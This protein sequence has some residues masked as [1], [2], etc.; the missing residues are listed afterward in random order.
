MATESA[1]VVILCKKTNIK[2][3]VK[4]R[5]S[6]IFYEYLKYQVQ[7]PSKKIKQ[8]RNANCSGCDLSVEKLSYKLT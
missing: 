4:K 5:E 6:R 2:K 7:R 8:L 3:I 1:V